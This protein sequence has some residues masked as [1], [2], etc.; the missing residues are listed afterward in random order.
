MQPDLAGRTRSESSRSASSVFP[1]L[2]AD[3]AP[4]VARAPAAIADWT[5]APGPSDCPDCGTTATNVQG[6]PDC[7]DCAWTGRA[8]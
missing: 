4:D 2:T 1:Y 7:P 3:D 8:D 6:L 5:G